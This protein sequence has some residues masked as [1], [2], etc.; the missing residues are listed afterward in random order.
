M[1][2]IGTDTDLSTRETDGFGAERMNGH[3]HE[4]D[5]DLLAGREEHI[6]LA[7]GGVVCDLL[8]EIDEHVCLVPHRAHDHHDLVAILLRTNRSPCCCANLFRIGNACTAEF[9][10]DK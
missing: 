5:A 8:G 4:G 10:N 2:A 7:A 6:H 9:L 1:R 3:G